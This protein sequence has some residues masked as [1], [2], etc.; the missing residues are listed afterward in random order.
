MTQIWPGFGVA[1]VPTV[2]SIICRP[3]AVVMVFPAV[4]AA[5]MVGAHT[6]GMATNVIAI[7][8][9]IGIFA[10]RSR[11]MLGTFRYERSVSSAPRPGLLAQWRTQMLSFR[12]SALAPDLRCAIAH[13]G[14]SRFPVRCFAS[15]RNDRVMDCFVGHVSFSSI[16]LDSDGLYW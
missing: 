3:E 9:S 12:D 13:R 16:G 11:R 4:W 6:N 5:A 2:E 8:A 1:P 14:I 7:A 15:P 10:R